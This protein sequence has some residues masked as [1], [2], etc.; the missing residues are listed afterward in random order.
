MVK[1]HN[2]PAVDCTPFPPVEATRRDCPDP[3]EQMFSRKSIQ[4]LF[5]DLHIPS[6][7]YR[8]SMP[9]PLSVILDNLRK[10]YAGRFI[11]STQSAEILNSGTVPANGSIGFDSS[12]SLN[13]GMPLVCIRG[14][15][16]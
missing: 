7:W 1:I 4:D 5:D 16:T 14:T 9:T 12:Q 2:Q 8:S 3:E 11:S 15:N 13:D 6:S 10:L